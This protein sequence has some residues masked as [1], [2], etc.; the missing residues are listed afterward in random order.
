MQ[1]Y[2]LIHILAVFYHLDHFADYSDGKIRGLLK[3]LW[4]SGVSGNPLTLQPE[5]S[6]RLGLIPGRAFPL[7]RQGSQTGLVLSYF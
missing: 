6:G 3:V 4:R 1:G 5:Q 7:E 2:H